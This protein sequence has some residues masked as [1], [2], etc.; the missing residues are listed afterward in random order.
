[1]EGKGITQSFG[2]VHCQIQ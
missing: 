2:T 1:V